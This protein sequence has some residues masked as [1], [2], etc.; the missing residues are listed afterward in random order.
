M[1]GEVV[2]KELAGFGSYEAFE[3]ELLNLL[4][5]F[6]GQSLL[7]IDHFEM[8]HDASK[9][10][11]RLVSIHCDLLLGGIGETDKPSVGL[12][13]SCRE[14]VPMWLSSKA[15]ARGMSRSRGCANC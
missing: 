9:K 11:V 7:F 6:L 14:R 3:V 13:E 2:L 15:Y 10:N 1:F 4:S 5:V 12:S 8:I